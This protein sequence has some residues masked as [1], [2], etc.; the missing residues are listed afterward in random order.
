[1]TDAFDPDHPF[2]IFLTML[3]G[4]VAAIGGPQ[5]AT[6]LLGER[7]A[8]LLRDPAWEVTVKADGTIGLTR[9]APVRFSILICPVERHAARHQWRIQ[10]ST[11]PSYAALDDMTRWELGRLHQ[12]ITELVI[13]AEEVEDVDVVAPGWSEP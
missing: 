5:A 2:L 13:A 8:W 11:D 9:Q 1:M 10:F 4:T 3:D 12:A 6:Q 7:V